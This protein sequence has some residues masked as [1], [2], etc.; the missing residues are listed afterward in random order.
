MANVYIV[1]HAVGGYYVDNWTSYFRTRAEAEVEYNEC[2]SSVGEDPV[3]ISLIELNAE[4]LHAETV[5][6]WSGN[7]DD[8]E[9]ELGDEDYVGHVGIPDGY[10]PSQDAN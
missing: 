6:T 5:L 8:L 9:D 1:N 7:I 10:D 3:I 2:V 4:T